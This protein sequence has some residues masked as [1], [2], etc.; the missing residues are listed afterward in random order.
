MR[1]TWVILFMA[2]AY[3]LASDRD[4]ADAELMDGHVAE[5]SADAFC[6]SP[7]ISCDAPTARFL[8]LSNSQLDR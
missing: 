3:A 5:I 4:F 7:R 6:L 1:N 2:L 8:A